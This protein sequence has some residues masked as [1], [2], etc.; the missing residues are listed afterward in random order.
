MER[1]PFGRDCKI[2]AVGKQRNGKPRF[3]CMNHQSSATG[4]YGRRLERC[5]GAYRAVVESDAKELDP[6]DYPGGLA[7]WGAVKPVYDS[8]GFPTKKESTSTRA[9]MPA[10]PKKLM[11][12]SRPLRSA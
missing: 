6:A 1:A 10:A 12:L 8:T 5:E 7:L 9:A 3:W 2:E 4:K 11:I